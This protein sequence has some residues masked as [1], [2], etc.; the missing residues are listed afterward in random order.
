MRRGSGTPGRGVCCSPAYA[1]WRPIPQPPGR[2]G[3][4]S[5]SA[6]PVSGPNGG[7]SGP[8]GSRDA[9]G[10]NRQ[11]TDVQRVLNAHLLDES[12][13][14]ETDDVNAADETEITEGEHIDLRIPERLPGGVPLGLTMVRHGIICPLQIEMV[15]KYGLL[16]PA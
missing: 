9:V 14:P 4:R 3:L 5:A 1:P 16:I 7:R 2:P 10:N 6:V 11:Q 15:A 12:R 13:Q 8:S